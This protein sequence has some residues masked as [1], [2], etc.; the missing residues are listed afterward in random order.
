M[1][2]AFGEADSKLTYFIKVAAPLC[3]V[4]VPAL[5]NLPISSY[6]LWCKIAPCMSI[7]GILH[8][9]LP[10]PGEDLCA[11]PHPCVPLSSPNL[12]PRSRAAPPPGVGKNAS[13]EGMQESRQEQESFPRGS[14]ICPSLTDAPSHTWPPSPHVL[15]EALC[16][17]NV[18]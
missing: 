16:S 14:R 7:T 17:P 6:L 2:P 9:P 18:G 5:T 11:T 4:G 3:I 8:L 13:P 10:P 15:L 12:Y 1:L